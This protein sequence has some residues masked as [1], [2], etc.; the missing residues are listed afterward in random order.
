MD[1]NNKLLDTHEDLKLQFSY[2]KIFKELSQFW[3]ITKE[4][5]YMHIL[6]RVEEFDLCHIIKHYKVK[7][8]RVITIIDKL[9][10]NGRI[11]CT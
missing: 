2:T 5:Y 9:Q 8:E 4:L 1:S 6:Y 3:R 7:A 10:M 11:I